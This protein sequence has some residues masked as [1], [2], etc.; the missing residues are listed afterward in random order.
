[1]RFL[2]I[3]TLND[4]SPR[5]LCK[6]SCLSIYIYIYTHIK[7][8]YIYIYICTHT[9]IY[10]YMYT[11]TYKLSCLPW[12]VTPASSRHGS[13]SPELCIC[14]Y[15]Y[16]SLYIYIYRERDTYVYVYV[17]VYI[18]YIYIYI[19]IYIERE[20]ERER[21]I[22]CQQLRSLRVHWR[23]RHPRKPAHP[24]QAAAQNYIY[25]TIQYIT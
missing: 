1:M 11:Y 4:R 25:K 8:I 21:E 17:Y 7:H 14:A 24:N 6:L 3:S 5:H 16:L 20:R 18:L 9:Y 15:T 12:E 22:S 2:H 10:I 13:R 19:Y 23:T